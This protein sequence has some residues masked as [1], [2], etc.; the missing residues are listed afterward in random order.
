MDT[1]DALG[2]IIKVR[3]IDVEHVPCRLWGTLSNIL[4]IGF[5]LGNRFGGYL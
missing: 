3:A 2:G 4:G 5:D 1:T